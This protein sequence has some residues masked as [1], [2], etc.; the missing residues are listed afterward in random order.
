MHSSLTKLPSFILGVLFFCSG[1]LL[2]I[3]LHLYIHDFAQAHEVVVHANANPP[4]LTEHSFNIPSSPFYTLG[5]REETRGGAIHEDDFTF[6]EPFGRFLNHFYNPITEQNTIL[7]SQETARDRATRLWIDAITAYRN[8]LRTGPDGAFHLLGR[9]LH[10]LQDMTSPAHVHNDPHAAGDGFEA[11]GVNHFQE[12]NFS[13][14]SP[15]FP[16]VRNAVGGENGF[17]DDVAWQVYEFT[18][19]RGILTRT[20]PQPD[21]ELQRMFPSL[22]SNP[23]SGGWDIDNIGH[24][25]GA[26]GG[27]IDGSDDWWPMKNE[28]ERPR[29]SECTQRIKRF[30]RGGFSRLGVRGNFYIENSGGEE[31]AL[32]PRVYEKKLYTNSN[33]LVASFRYHKTPGD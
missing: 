28:K 12:Y 20:N 8:N 9:V 24:S 29:G 2:L 22:T 4:G 16:P 19:F 17:I 3:G 25:S 5:D 32:T 27:N 18:T 13:G 6:D 15:R 11:W 14:V 7:L 23:F 33:E 30:P 21:S 31:E 26:C 1:V 10:L